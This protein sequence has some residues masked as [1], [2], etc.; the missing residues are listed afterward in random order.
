MDR[1]PSRRI[2][3]ALYTIL[4]GNPTL[5]AAREVP[6]KTR[7]KM[8]YRLVG[9]AV[10]HAAA[11]IGENIDCRTLFRAVEGE[12][13]DEVSLAE[14]L[15][16]MARMLPHHFK[17]QHVCDKIDTGER[18]LRDFFC[19]QLPPDGRASSK[20]VGRVLRGHVG[21][22][23]VKEGKTF[24]LQSRQARKGGKYYEVEITG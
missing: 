18:L 16:M 11:Q 23:V 9:S 15:D 12:D 14:V 22:P 13:E 2:L 8:W 7:F 17:A 21:E 1:E 10:E 6:M 5:D 20:S 3:Q 4:L 19:P 24:I